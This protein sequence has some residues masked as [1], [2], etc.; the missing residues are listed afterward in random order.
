VSVLNIL[1]TGSPGVGKTTLME[2]IQKKVKG[3]GYNIGGVY[4]PE[5]REN[6]RRTGFGIVDIATGRKGVLA[7]INSSGPT[8]GKYHVNLNFWKN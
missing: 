8:V 2:A 1:I 5:I 7:S 3:R 6:N 4:C